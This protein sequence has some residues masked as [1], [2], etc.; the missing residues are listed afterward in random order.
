MHA[1]AKK[2]EHSLSNPR[3]IESLGNKAFVRKT[4]QYPCL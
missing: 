4:N 2:K 1:A 3:N